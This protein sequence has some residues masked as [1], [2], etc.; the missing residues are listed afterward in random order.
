M[1]LNS[2][3]KSRGASQS[4]NSAAAGQQPVDE[5]TCSH[6]F[7]ACQHPV[8]S[9]PVSTLSKGP[10][11]PGPGTCQAQGTLSNGPLVSKPPRTPV[12][13]VHRATHRSTACPSYTLMCMSM[14]SHA[15]RSIGTQTGRHACHNY[16][17]HNYIHHEFIGISM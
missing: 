4:A 14:Q 11:H 12:Y 1:V 17:G 15:G 16:V 9:R 6:Q 3:S 7:T 8:S 5:G 2:R 10:R 13:R